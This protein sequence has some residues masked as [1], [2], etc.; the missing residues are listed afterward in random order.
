MILSEAEKARLKADVVSCL[1]TDPE[2][3]RIV[4]FGSFLRSPSPEDM[5][6]AVFQEST[7]TYLALALKYRRQTREISR[8]MPLDIIPLR[9]DRRG[10]PFLD[11]VC[12]GEVIYER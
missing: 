10:D 9:A 12:A 3:C 5:D 11:E 7:E 1:S 8:R 2:I 6:I 4:V